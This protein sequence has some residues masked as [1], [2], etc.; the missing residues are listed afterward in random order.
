MVITVITNS[1]NKVTA[2]ERE[3]CKI[4]TEVFDNLYINSWKDIY[5]SIKYTARIFKGDY[6]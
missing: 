6:L 5:Y 2:A 1:D 4:T 3:M